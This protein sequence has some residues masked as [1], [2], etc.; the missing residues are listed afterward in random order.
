MGLIDAGDELEG[1]PGADP[2]SK[3]GRSFLG[4]GPGHQSQARVAFRRGQSRREAQSTEGG[5][6]P[7][8]LTELGIS[9][10]ETFPWVWSG[11]KLAD[12]EMGIFF[13]FKAN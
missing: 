4:A 5:V 13:F 9:A 3:Q 1:T 6:R 7:P 2:R 8:F 12:A 11:R 10:P